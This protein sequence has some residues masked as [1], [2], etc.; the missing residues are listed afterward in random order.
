MDLA[1]RLTG[2]ELRLAAIEALLSPA[3]ADQLGQGLLDLYQRQVAILHCLSKLGELVGLQE[4]GYLAA[5]AE[6]DNGS[7]QPLQ[8]TEAHNRQGSRDPLKHRL[9][10][11]IQASRQQAKSRSSA[12]VNKA[13]SKVHI[14]LAQELQQR[15]V[16]SF[17]FLRAP[18]DYYDHNLEYRRRALG[19][20]SIQQL[21]KSLVLENTKARNARPE[22][23]H[24]ARYFCVVIQ[25]RSL[26]ISS[27]S[28]L[29]PPA[30]S[31]CCIRPDVHSGIGKAPKF[32]S[33]HLHAA[34]P[35]EH[36]HASQQPT[37]KSLPCLQGAICF[38]T[39]V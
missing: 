9:T 16:D 19:A 34:A 5:S 2:L 14:K 25:V 30:H 21:C 36:L 32:I 6:P 3:E 24:A 31:C 7:Q 28:E 39:W 37:Q 29:L 27:S 4:T 8:S 12:S 15:G 18:P 33:I 17:E 35:Q 10:L 1:G 20:R 13:A 11:S 23:P 26:W 22:S 38:P